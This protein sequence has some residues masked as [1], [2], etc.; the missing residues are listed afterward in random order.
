MT[1]INKLN[2]FRMTSVIKQSHVA[3]AAAAASADE[4]QRDS[5]ALAMED[6]I[7]RKRPGLTTDSVRVNNVTGL[8]FK[9]KRTWLMRL[10]AIPEVVG[11]EKVNFTFLLKT[12]KL[13]RVLRSIKKIKKI[14]TN[15]K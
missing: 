2:G 14:N 1:F 3:A 13:S 8:L 11:D 6:G 9:R 15:R 5:R 12:T 4:Y 7:N 10:G